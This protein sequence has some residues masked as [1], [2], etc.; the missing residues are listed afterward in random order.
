[1]VQLFVSKVAELKYWID[2][3]KIPPQK[4]IPVLLEIEALRQQICTL[5]CTLVHLARKKSGE[6]EIRTRNPLRGTS[7]PMKPLAIRLLSWK[8][9]PSLRTL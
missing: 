1:M 9:R 5:L 6:H 8:F 7:F 2:D 4:W 3:D